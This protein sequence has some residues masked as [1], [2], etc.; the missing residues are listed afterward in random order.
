MT[1][2]VRGSTMR[3]VRAFTLVEILVVIA[4]LAVLIGLLLP[5]VQRVRE[6]GARS[7]CGNNLRQLAIALQNYHAAHGCFPPGMIS[8]IDNTCD[9]EASGFTLLLP[10]LEQTNVFDQ[11]HF[12]VP[13]FDTANYTAVGLE[14]TIFFCPANRKGG[15]IDLAPIA[16]QWNCPLPPKAGCVDYAF[17]KGANASLTRRVDRIPREV[18]G[19]FH[20][21]TAETVTAG[22]KLG[23]IS[24]GAT[25]TFALGDAAGGNAF[26]KVRDPKN[27]NQAAIDGN[28]GKPAIPDQSWGAAGVEEPAHPW[29]GSVFATTAQYG[30]AP[31]PRDEPMNRKLVAASYYGGDPGGN[32]SNRDSV[33]GFRSL[34]PAGCNFAF[35]DGS[36]RFVKQQIDPAVYRALSTFAGGEANASD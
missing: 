33:S 6:A 23:E 14:V 22:V 32:A 20:V 28:S 19:A 12:D 36:V 10:H 13:W 25:Q 3:R 9:A 5:A 8:S 15:T 24:D 30:L 18:R 4:I 35:C 7:A 17:S 1:A 16:L 31:D 2:E 29:Y 11:Y 21:A 34:H 26:Y 27:P